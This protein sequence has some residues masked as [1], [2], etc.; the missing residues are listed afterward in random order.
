MIR[1]SKQSHTD[2]LKEKLTSEQ[3]S[4]KDW[5]K[6]LKHFI[7][8]AKSS[9]IPP[10]NDNDIIVSDPTE[11]ANLLNNYF[12]DQTILNDNNVEVPYCP[13]HNVFSELDS[14]VL[15][16][17]EVS[18]ILKSLPIGKAVGPDGVSNRILKELAEKIDEPLSYLFNQSLSQGHVPDGWKKSHVSPIPKND[19][20]AL[21]SNYRPISLLS[22]IDKAFEKCIFKHVY[23]HLHVNNILTPYQSGFIPGDSTT[24]QLTFLYNTFSEALDSGKEVRVVF[25]D[26]SK[27][28]DRVWHKG[29]LCK[30]KAAGIT[31]TLLDWFKDYLSDRKQRVVIPGATSDWNS[32]KAAVP[33]G[34]ILGPLL[35]LIFINDIVTDVGCNIR[36][37]ADDTS[38]Y[39][40]VEHPDVAARCINFDLDII[41]D[42]ACK[43]L[44]KFSPPKTDSMLLS[45]K[46]NKPYHPPL[47]MS[48]VQIKEV[49]SHKHLGIHL[50]SDCTWHTHIGYIKEKAWQRLNVMRRLKF[51]LDRRSLEIVYTSFIRPLLEYGDTIWDN[52]TLYEKQ[53]LDKIQNEAARI[54][55]GA[56][57]L[58]SIQD[59]HNEVGWESLQTRRTNHKLSLFFKMQHDLTPPYLTNLVP[60]SVSETSRYPLRNADD[61]ATI[62]CKTQYHY[63]SFL[64]SVVREWNN[65]PQQ[66]KQINSLTS[67]KAYLT[68]DKIKVPKYFYKGKCKLQVMHTR[69][70]TNC[71]ALN[72]DLFRKNIVDSP[73]YTCGAIENAY[74]F[75]F[76]CG[77]YTNQRN[78]LFHDLNFIQNINLKLLLF[79]D[80]SRSIE[81]NTGIFEAVQ[82]LLEKQNDLPTLR[83]I[84]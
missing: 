73:S 68:R 53:E 54:A 12:R 25:C 76:T 58:V 4:S 43:W 38:L 17:E 44:V 50:S 1:K 16:R 63:S 5:W 34:S 78:N 65:L 56:T 10:L 36:L 62:Q 47:F 27:A 61:Y 21:P 7:S 19:N 2:K 83:H 52:C 71:S 59:L 69:I 84:N 30:L 39:I 13:S 29:L 48:N 41:F 79:G 64:P 9:S 28:F 51:I 42:W 23:N 37:F 74:H 55:T 3:L 11:K 14:L 15:N 18:S 82:N 20:T 66:A 72:S 70:R 57:A 49:T 67:F 24:N 77:R 45:R 26:I 46:I 6:T 40:I 31:G 33:Q 35:F 75:F 81:D 8:P 32:I 22:N 80:V 60:P